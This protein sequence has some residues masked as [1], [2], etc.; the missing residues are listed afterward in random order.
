MLYRRKIILG[1]IEVFGGTVD[2]LCLQ[3][4]LFLLSQQ[5]EKP[6]YEFIPYHYGGYS[7]TAQWDINKLCQVCSKMYKWI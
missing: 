6:V 1:L 5:Q 7:F 3:K 4:M 2:K